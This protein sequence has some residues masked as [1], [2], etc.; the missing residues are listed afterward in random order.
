MCV[1]EA[2]Q[3]PPPVGKPVGMGNTLDRQ[4]ADVVE[5]CDPPEGYGRASGEHGD[6]LVAGLAR[7][8]V[9]V[10]HDRLTTILPPCVRSPN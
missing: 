8:G 7:Y 5:G 6:D 9:R 3:R 4:G 10:R 2:S 1:R